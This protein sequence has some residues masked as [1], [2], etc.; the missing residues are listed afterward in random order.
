MFT[1]GKVIRKRQSLFDSREIEDKSQDQQYQMK[2]RYEVDQ[3]SVFKGN[4]DFYEDDLVKK[5]RQLRPG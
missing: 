4:F 2:F 1:Q 5:K 3:S